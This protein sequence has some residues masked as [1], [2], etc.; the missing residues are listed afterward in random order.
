MAKPWL[1]AGPI[2]AFPWTGASTLPAAKIGL[3][4]FMAVVGCL[5]A[6]L[7]SAYFMRAHSTDW[8]SLP[9]PDLLW[10]N[11]AVLV[12]SSVALQ[13]AHVA[14]DREKLD[15]VKAALLLGGAFAVIFLI[16]Q[17]LLWRQL[18]AA[19]YFLAR[20]PANAFFYLIIAAHGLHLS[21]GLVALG[22][23]T[24]RVWRPGHQ[25]NQQRLSIDLCT[26]YWHFLLL[27]WLVLLALLTH[28]IENVVV[29]CGQFFL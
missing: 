20:N 13:W 12:M 21:G 9:V 25:V 6:L 27:V 23:T 1:E 19:G 14:A 10:F 26:T 24:V 18:T 29:I 4:L 3:R 15:D 17:I 28:G 11:T 7:I 16:G 22:R 5:F 2:D 8:Q